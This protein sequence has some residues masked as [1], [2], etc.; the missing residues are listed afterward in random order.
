MKVHPS[1]LWLAWKIELKESDLVFGL[2]SF[3]VL[4]ET[5]ILQLLLTDS[6]PMQPQYTPSSGK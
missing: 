2:G 3:F 1:G 5:M 4:Q 6:P